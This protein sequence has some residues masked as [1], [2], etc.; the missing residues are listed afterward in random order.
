MCEFN[1]FMIGYQIIMG[2]A[3]LNWP[4]ELLM[5]VSLMIS[6]NL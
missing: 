6:Q 3:K 4:N 1:I 5:T 2:V